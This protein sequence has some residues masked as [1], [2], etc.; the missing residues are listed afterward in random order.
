MIRWTG[1]LLFVALACG[2]DDG[3][4]MDAGGTDSD[5]AGDYFCD[6]TGCFTCL[7]GECTEVPPP[8]R[9]TCSGDSECSEAVCTDLGCTAECVADFSCAQGTVCRDGLC[10]GPT[11]P[12]PTPRP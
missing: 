8:E 11:E 1:I 2:D 5:P 3:S 9:T 6:E 12:D 7:D 10:V 4:P